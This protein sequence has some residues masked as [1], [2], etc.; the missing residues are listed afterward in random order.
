MVR[1]PC[2]V[3]KQSPTLSQ[4]RWFG[5]APDWYCAQSGAH[6]ENCFSTHFLQRLYEV[7]GA[8]NT[9]NQH[10]EG[11]RATPNNHTSSPTTP[12]HSKPHKRTF[13]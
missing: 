13:D 4:D 9:L 11:T 3:I 12:T 6:A 2:Q 1:C 5:G 10:I 7:V 8:I